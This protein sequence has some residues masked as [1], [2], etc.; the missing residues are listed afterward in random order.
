MDT[1]EEQ[2]R[3]EER[4][5][6]EQCTEEKEIEQFRL[7]KN[8]YTEAKRMRICKKCYGEN[9]EETQRRSQEAM[10]RREMERQQQQQREQEEREARRLAREER[11]REIDE[12]LATVPTYP[13]VSVDEIT[14]R[15]HRWKHRDEAY[16]WLQTLN[17]REYVVIDTETT[18]S[19]RYSQVIEIAILN[20]QGEQIF[21]S[22]LK[23]S[24]PIE[25]IATSV[26][27]L[28]EKDV[29][30]APTFAEIAQD[31][32]SSFQNKLI[33]AYNAAFDIRLLFQTARAFEVH[34]PLMEAA[35]LMYCYSKI[36]GEKTPR[37]QYRRFRLGDACQAMQIEVPMVQFGDERIAMLKHRAGDD[38]RLLYELLQ[39]M[40]ESSHSR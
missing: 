17:T 13:Y 9:L 10:R 18:G 27:G 23:P 25:P 31:L 32:Y 20:T 12:F 7:V 21:H 16:A 11:Q 29:K 3:D 6:C 24:T 2:T 30:D 35:C 38:T 1:T 22:L 36:C 14:S 39:C 15:Y 28:T 19:M 5:R 34:F 33:L 4:K 37:G 8:M 26:H 40:I